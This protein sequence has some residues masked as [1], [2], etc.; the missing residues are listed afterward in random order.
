MAQARRHAWHFGLYDNLGRAGRQ[1]LNMGQ[2]VAG[3]GAIHILSYRRDRLDLSL[4]ANSEMDGDRIFP[5][6]APLL[7]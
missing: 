2:R 5:V 6:K 7:Y 4:A 3:A 1:P